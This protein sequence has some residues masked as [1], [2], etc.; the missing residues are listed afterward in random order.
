MPVL[1]PISVDILDDLG[2]IFERLAEI[3]GGARRRNIVTERCAVSITIDRDVKSRVDET[4]PRRRSGKTS[5]D[6][7][8]FPLFRVGHLVLLISNGS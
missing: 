1:F 4:Q 7:C 6:D 2:V 8:D 5:S 3:D